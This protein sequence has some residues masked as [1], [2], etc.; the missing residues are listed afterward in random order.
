V[1]ATL[2]QLGES[3][4]GPTPSASSSPTSAQFVCTEPIARIGAVVTDETGI[5]ES[6]A[7]V[8]PTGDGISDN[9]SFVAR[10]PGGDYSQLQIEWAGNP[11]A[12]A[13]GFKLAR[14]PGYVIDIGPR[15]DGDHLGAP[16]GDS[17]VCVASRVVHAVRLQ[18]SQA[19]DAAEVAFRETDNSEPTPSPID[20]GA[21]TALHC[22]GSDRSVLVLDATNKA[23]S[24]SVDPSRAEGSPGATVGNPDGDETLVAVHWRTSACITNA[25]VV[26][27][28][29]AD[30]KRFD[31]SEADIG[32]FG[33]VSGIGIMVTFKE[34][35]PADTVQVDF[36]GLTLQG[37]QTVT[38]AGVF[39]LVLLASA[40]EVASAD[41]IENLDAYLT[42]IGKAPVVVTGS[43]MGLAAPGVQQVGGDLA[44]FAAMSADCVS[45]E[46]MSDVPIQIPFESTG[47]MAP[48]P[49]EPAFQPITS[50][51]RLVLPIGDWELS[52]NENFVVG[53]GC[54]GTRVSAT[55]SI[56]IHVR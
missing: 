32:C 38:T 4:S 5:V 2:P 46:L 34:P 7:T 40:A 16:L 18:L 42:L 13:I 8:A 20:L 23:T 10:N 21:A 12:A 11:C 22:T 55:T 35:V 56:T 43:G 25:V 44:A 15:P 14:S 31:I 37:V 29:A 1:S 45:Y 30:S 54:V 49:T 39:D 53:E 50:D 3:I 24:C 48:N 51:Q 33:P 28:A 6:C 36:G 27:T 17:W 9:V 26:V 52:M 47:V 19:V 41:A